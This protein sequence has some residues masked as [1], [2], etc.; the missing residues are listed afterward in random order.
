M[1]KIL[2]VAVIC[3]FSAPLLSENSVRIDCS[4][5]Q[6][7]RGKAGIWVDLK[8]K[9]HLNSLLKKFGSSPDEVHYLKENANRDRGYAFIPYSTEYLT[10]L[11]ES[12]KSQ[13][14]VE[15]GELEFIWPIRAVD[16]ISSHF[17]LRGGRLHTGVDLPAPRGVPIVAA[18]DGRVVQSCY[19]G[20]H[21]KTLL[22]E[23]RGNYYTRYSHNSVMFV[24][25]GELVRKGQVIALVG[26]T[27]NSTGNHLH[28][29]IRYNDIP[30]NPVD[31]L[32]EK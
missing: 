27:G 28:F 13:E 6:R 24:G 10:E 29:E 5:I 14:I 12:D 32:P 19:I 4:E 25:E 26:S 2:A 11:V 18:M 17:G 16:R 7:F 31:F 9:W 1:K 21:G 8:S 15:S 30:L 20:G 22:I 3:M 23:H